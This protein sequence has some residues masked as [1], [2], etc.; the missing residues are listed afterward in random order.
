[1]AAKSDKEKSFK[2]DVPQKSAGIK[3]SSAKSKKIA[4]EDVFDLEDNEATP[5]AGKRSASVKSKSDDDDN[6]DDIEE[7]E[8]PVKAEEDEDW[9]PDFNEFDLPK[10][11]KKILPTKK[12]SR[13]SDEDFKIDDEFKDLF[14]SSS[15]RK[16]NED[17]DD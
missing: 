5:K 17:D 4:D 3:K 7:D 11:S 14:G 2:K 8:T 12:G 9:D 15:S 1:M 16:Y 13:D 10:S 6:I